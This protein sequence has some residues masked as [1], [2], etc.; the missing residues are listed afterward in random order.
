MGGGV[1]SLD[2][3]EGRD[4]PDTVCSSLGL[5]PNR[6]KWSLDEWS[7]H[8]FVSYEGVRRCPSW[9]RLRR[10]RCSAERTGR[11][12]IEAVLDEL[13][14]TDVNDTSPLELMSRVQEWQRRLD[15]E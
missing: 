14:A 4:Q 10:V 6:P 8:D 2:Y 12:G 11:C 7:I 5:V 13:R 3:F 1:C 9:H 15:E